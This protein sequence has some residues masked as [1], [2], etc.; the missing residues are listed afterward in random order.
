MAWVKRARPPL[1]WT[2]VAL[3]RPVGLGVPTDRIYLNERLRHQHEPDLDQALA[4]I[5]AGDTDTRSTADDRA[6]AF[7]LLPA[8]H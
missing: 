6:K 3:G 1:V 5:R 2:D 4:A 8:S 7:D